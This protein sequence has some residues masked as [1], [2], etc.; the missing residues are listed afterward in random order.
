MSAQL[1][2]S[3]YFTRYVTTLKSLLNEEHLQS[4][5]R[6]H[7]VIALGSFIVE[8]GNCKASA[9]VAVQLCSR[10]GEIV[11]ESKRSRRLPTAFIGK[12]WS[13]S[14][15]TLRFKLCGQPT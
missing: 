7:S 2:G 12:V 14:D 11:E 1:S 13:D 4:S 15:S 5:P 8:Q 9:D 10:L 3:G 6:G